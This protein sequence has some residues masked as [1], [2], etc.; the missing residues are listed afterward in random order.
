MGWYTEV[1]LI[2]E[3]L[4]SKKQAFELGK[5]IF[6]NDS[7]SYS[8]ETFFIINTNKE[9]AIYYHYERRKVLPYW[10]INEISKQLKHVKF[11]LIGSCP[12]F[13]SGPGGL[14]RIKEGEILDSYG[15][16]QSNH[17]R[18]HI[19]EN[20]I[21]FKRSVFDW[22][23][24]TGLEETLRENYISK[25]PKIWC[26]GDYVKRLIPIGGEKELSEL[27]HKNTGTKVEESNWEK[28][29]KFPLTKD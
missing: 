6:D 8:K 26:E 1:I 2:A 13:I 12:D 27:I 16:W 18:N 28:Q 4:D 10:I 3:N 14:I 7:R 29:V 20:P 24:S 9:F 19:I 22:Y 5:Q 17:L 11:T 25:F 21:Q 15:I 23:K